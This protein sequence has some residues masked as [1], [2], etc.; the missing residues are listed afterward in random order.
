MITKSYKAAGLSIHQFNCLF[1][2]Q[3][4]AVC[5][6]VCIGSWRCHIWTWQETLKNMRPSPKHGTLLLPNDDDDD[7][8][9]ISNL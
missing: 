6:K 2:P 3:H 7:D 1:Q 5:K 4:D 8:D 9:M